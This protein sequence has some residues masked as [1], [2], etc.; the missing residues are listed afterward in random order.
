MVWNKGMPYIHCVSPLIY[1]IP[2]ERYKKTW[3]GE[4]NGVQELLVYAV[5]VNLFGEN[6]GA[7]KRNKEALLFISKEVGL[8]VNREYKN[9]L[10]SCHQTAGH[11]HNIKTVT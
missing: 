1:N 6:T 8:E 5:A 7:T 2:L 11:N 9:M 10:M 3:R 4:L